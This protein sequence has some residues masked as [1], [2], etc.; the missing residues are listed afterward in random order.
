M[1]LRS[2]RCPSC[3]AN[4]LFDSKNQVFKCQ[5]CGSI[6]TD[7]KSAGPSFD[8]QG[9]VKTKRTSTIIAIAV[10]IFVFIIVLVSFSIMMFS[11]QQ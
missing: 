11:M 5:Y 3:G 8:D 1:E 9:I 2:M 7:D 4:I 10:A 6:Y